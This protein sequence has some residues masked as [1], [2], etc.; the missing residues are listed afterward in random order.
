M[1]TH[2]TAV[3]L[4]GPAHVAADAAKK[5]EDF[6]AE[7]G[8]DGQDDGFFGGGKSNGANN[9][10]A[11]PA[12]VVSPPAAPAPVPAPTVAGAPEGAPSTDFLNYSEPLEVKSTIG[13]RK[14]QPRRGVSAL[15][16]AISLQKIQCQ[17][18][19]FAS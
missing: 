6:F 19:L 4:D 8:S 10:A 13:V 17:R 15:F 16:T 7:C 1:K 5:E 11:K 3:F 14:I 18:F 9:N 12:A 2:G